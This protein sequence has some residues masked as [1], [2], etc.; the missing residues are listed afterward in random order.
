MGLT[1]S[2]MAQIVAAHGNFD[3]AHCIE[4]GEQVPME[5]LRAAIQVCADHTGWG[6]AGPG[7]RRGGWNVDEVAGEG[8]IWRVAA[9][10]AH[11]H[12]RAY[13]PEHAR[14]DDTV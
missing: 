5:E 8:G 12:R 14:C 13:A 3:S 2:A 4:T 10:C 6:Q 9:A 7:I 11:V 1:L